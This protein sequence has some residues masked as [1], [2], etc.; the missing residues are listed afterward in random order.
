M[1]KITCV[2]I[3]MLLFPLPLLAGKAKQAAPAAPAAPAAIVTIQSPAANAHLKG[4]SHTIRGAVAKK[5]LTNIYCIVGPMNAPGKFWVQPAVLPPGP[6]GK[7]MASFY[8]GT[9][10]EGS[11]EDYR[12]FVFASAKPLSYKEGDILDTAKVTGLMKTVPYAEV[13]VFRDKD[14]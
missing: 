14:K 4:V 3:L 9:P 7:W 2:F 12:I 5:D 11:G 1:K 13:S 8:L 6:D 10:S